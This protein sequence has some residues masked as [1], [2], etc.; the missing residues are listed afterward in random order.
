MNGKKIK[1]HIPIPTQLNVSP[2]M[3]DAIVGS[4]ILYDLYGWFFVSVITRTGDTTQHIFELKLQHIFEL[5]LTL[6]SIAMTP[7]YVS[8]HLTHT[9]FFLFSYLS[10]YRML[11]FAD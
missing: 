4:N 10:T 1:K 8:L 6:G 2:Y 11:P 9:D 7:L 5:K 3:S